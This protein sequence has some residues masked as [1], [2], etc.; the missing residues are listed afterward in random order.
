M[1]DKTKYEDF[2]TQ[3]LFKE[4]VQ[5]KSDPLQFL[6]EEKGHLFVTAEI[7][8][9]GSL[10]FEV[11]VKS[12]LDDESEWDCKVSNF[13]INRWFRTDKGTSGEKYKTLGLMLSAVK[14]GMEKHFSAKVKSYHIVLNKYRPK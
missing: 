11:I 12:T 1:T 3:E 4:Y 6:V 13:H 7:K 14:K 8:G 9:E 10:D 5:L 2:R